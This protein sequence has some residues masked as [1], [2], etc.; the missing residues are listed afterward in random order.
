ML[1]RHKY[2]IMLLSETWLKP[3]VP[4]RLLILPGYSIFRVDRPDGRGYGG[5]AIV[6]REELSMT[7]L[8]T[9][10][11]RPPDSRLESIWSLLK[12]DRGRQLL[13]CS[14]Y[15]PPRY[16]AAAL[17]ADFRDL[18]NQV[19][20]VIL[21]NPAVTLLICGDLNCDLLKSAPAPARHRLEEFLSD[22]SMH[23][24]VTAPTFK[25][26][27]LLDI[28]IVSSRSLVSDCRVSFCDFSPHHIIYSRVDV[29]RTRRKPIVTQSRCLRRLDQEAF[30][31][32]LFCADW[33]CV[34][35]L[36][37]VS[38]KWDAFLSTF[39]PILDKHAPMRS[40]RVRNPAAPPISPATSDL[41]SR[42]RAA[43]S[44]G[45]RDSAEYRDLNRAVRSGIRRD[46]RE[47]IEHR[48]RERGPSSIWQSI[49]GV[50]GGKRSGTPVLP[51]LSSDELNRFFVSVGPRVA[52]E[53]A[54]RGRGAATQ[55]V[56][57][58]PRVGA[59]GFKVSPIDIDTLTCTVLSMRNS[60]A[61]G[62][63]GVCV[64]GC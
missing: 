42:R 49:R 1:H 28:C 36:P 24:L 12:M 46:T 15:R 39:L 9:T 62:A 13:L 57:R 35:I 21:D 8:K 25:S 60:P 34:F 5:V 40:V 27:S 58:L 54:D 45:G 64:C 3:T 26:G 31:N 43:L 30:L 33:G 48:I 18:E 50:V 63:D 7:P 19:Q 22:Y 16:T 52:A 4:N 11:R 29:P 37:T 56:C 53:V 61:R 2:D 6:A 55:P 41:M 17:D 44:A 23:Q 10:T 14:L 59:C 38:E 20:R 51:Q 32:D 47:S